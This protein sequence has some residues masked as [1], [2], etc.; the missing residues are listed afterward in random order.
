MLYLVM[1]INVASMISLVMLHLM[2]LA[3]QVDLTSQAWI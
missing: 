3:E 2:V 1:L